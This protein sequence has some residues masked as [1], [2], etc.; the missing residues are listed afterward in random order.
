MGFKAQ[1]ETDN[2]DDYMKLNGNLK[3][4]KEAKKCPWCG[5]NNIQVTMKQTGDITMND[6]TTKPSEAYDVMCVECSMIHQR[7]KSEIEED[8]N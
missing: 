6:G 8:K 1:I 4:K 3:Q 2:I 7:H 5:S